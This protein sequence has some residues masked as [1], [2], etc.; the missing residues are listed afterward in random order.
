MSKNRNLLLIFTRNPELGKVKKR[1]AAETGDKAALEIYKFLLKHTAE[2]TKNVSADKEV[3]FSEAI[4]KGDFWDESYG[5]KLQKGNDLGERMKNAF[6]E[7]FEQGYNN[8]IIIGSDLYDLSSHDLEKAF[9]ALEN[10][11]YVIGPA[12]DGGYYL[13]GMKSL[14]STLFKN[15]AWSTASVFEETVRDIEAKKIHV[16]EERNDIDHLEDLKAHSE[17]QQLLAIS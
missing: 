12:Q 17:L 7:G 15:K 14:N 16:L 1:L 5:K 4:E 9:A 3:H 13:L 11:D 10:S 6:Q 2:V 8:I